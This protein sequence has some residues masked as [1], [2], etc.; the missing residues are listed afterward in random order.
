MNLSSISERGV[1][2]YFSKEPTLEL[3]AHPASCPMENL[4]HFLRRKTVRACTGE[5]APT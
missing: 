2:F 4:E 3:G 5:L 1:D